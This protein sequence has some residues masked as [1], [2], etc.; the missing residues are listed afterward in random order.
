MKRIILLLIVSM[1]MAGSVL[2]ECLFT[3]EDF[4]VTP[5][6]IGTEI[7]LTVK[8]EFSAR[9]SSWQVD[10][11]Y[12]EGLTPTRAEAGSDYGISY[13]NAYGHTAMY[14][15]SFYYTTSYSRFIGYTMDAGYWYDP[16]T[17]NLTSYGIIKWEGGT[18]EEMFILYVEVT[19]EF[20]L[21]A[22]Q[23]VDDRNLNH[24]VSTWLLLE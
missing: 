23:H 13:I 2:A 10:F 8:A 16:D 20:L 19:D 1:L 9:V 12:P 4:R 3:I 17:E 24:C 11:T 15:P 14:D 22:T 7:A 5:D 6:Q 21:I 18:Y